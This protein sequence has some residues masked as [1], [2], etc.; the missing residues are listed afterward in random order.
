MRPGD[1]VSL[2]LPTS[3]DFFFSFLGILCAGAVPVP[4]Y[5]P[6]RMDQLG[7]YLERHGRILS[8]AGAVVII[9]EPGPLMTVSKVLRDRVPTLNH[10][11]TVEDLG[12]AERGAGPAPV[13]PD[14]LGLIQY[15]SGSTGDPK[16]VSLRHRNLLANMRAIGQ[17]L[18][19]NPRDVCVSWLP[20]Y[21]DM[22]LIGKL[23]A[24]TVW[25]M[26][27]VIIPPQHFVR[28]PSSW[29]RAITRYK[30]TCFCYKECACAPDPPGLQSVSDSTGAY[31]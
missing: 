9:S 13:R 24:A 14:D 7:P 27:L 19:L 29:L 25:G 3:Q 2:V 15:T 28:F 23:L 10:A 17:N 4:I 26:P 16:G 18:A 22:G 1:R 8:N 30:G 12:E 21:H 11:V 31:P 20:L 5:P 6:I